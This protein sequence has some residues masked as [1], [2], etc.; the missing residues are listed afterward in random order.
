MWDTTKEGERWTCEMGE[1]DVLSVIKF[2]RM[3]VGGMSCEGCMLRRS[4]LCLSPSCQT[5][6]KTME[7]LRITTYV[8]GVF[9]LLGVGYGFM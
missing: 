8:C 1:V 4:I 3:R 7:A 2:E 6:S 5:F 9:V